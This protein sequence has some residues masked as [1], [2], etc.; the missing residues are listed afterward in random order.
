MR[1][2]V[3]LGLDTVGV[4]DYIFRTNDL[5]Q[6]VGASFLV[7]CAT[8]AWLVDALRPLRHNV[9]DLD[10][11][12]Q[13][14]SGA[15]IEDGALDAEVILTG[16]GNATIAFRDGDQARDF[17]Y[18][19]TRRLVVEAPGLQVAAASVA[20]E[21]DADAYG[22]EHGAAA[23][24]ARALDQVKMNLPRRTPQLGLSVTLQCDFTHLPATAVVDGQPVSAEVK[25]KL[26][27]APRAN[28]RLRRLLER[29]PAEE[30]EQAGVQDAFPLQIDQLGAT[31]GEK[32]LLAVIHTDG[33]G[34]SQRFCALSDKYPGKERNRVLVDELRALSVSVQDTSEQ[35]LIH[36]IR[37]LL[38]DIAWDADD[39][40]LK[41]AEAIPLETKMLP[42]RPVLYGGDDATFLCDGRIGLWLAAHYLEKVSSSAL[43]DGQKLYSR[44]GVAIV[45]AHYPFARAYR[46]AEELAASAKQF[47]KELEKELEDEGRAVDGVNVIDWHMSTSGMV[48]GLAEIRASEYQCPAGAL[49]MRPL[50]LGALPGGKRVAGE[51][52]SWETFLDIL[53]GFVDWHDKHNKAKALRGA[54]IRGGDAVKNFVTLNGK[55]PH[56]A[57]L[58]ASDQA[59]GWHGDR[60]AYFDAVEIMDLFVPLKELEDADLPVEA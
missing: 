39:Q 53:D 35:A 10:D 40:C 57:R 38:H 14:F 54:L 59:E 52:R 41:L 12:R 4:Q 42:L 36:T 25:A 3:L 16:G 34:M 55:L 8:R 26:D 33:N 5:K 29:I 20:F 23:A 44:A 9:R 51:W 46:L 2:G 1:K 56:S 58:D 28:S 18:T 24:L 22:G 15:R 49:N 32:S 13:P 21:M 7:D 30:W 50:Y 19:L 11:A 27:A 17:L 31:E 45:K 43:S 47:R 37:T 6:I 60:C 48:R